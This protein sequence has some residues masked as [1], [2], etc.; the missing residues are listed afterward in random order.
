MEVWGIELSVII[1]VN[2]LAQQGQAR[3][4]IPGAEKAKRISM[5]HQVSSRTQKPIKRPPVDLSSKAHSSLD[6]SLWRRRVLFDEHGYA[7]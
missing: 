4:L 1:P 5:D 2:T 6:V 3:V 7:S